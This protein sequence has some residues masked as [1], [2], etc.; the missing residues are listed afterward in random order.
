MFCHHAGNR[1][2]PASPKP[3]STNAIIPHVF[4]APS[5]FP[6]GS[7]RRWHAAKQNAKS[8]APSAEPSPITRSVA[9]STSR[10]PF[11]PL[12]PEVVT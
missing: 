1:V 6:C 4:P 10:Q 2:L 3:V 9:G 7:P 11:A 5:P 8:P 12:L